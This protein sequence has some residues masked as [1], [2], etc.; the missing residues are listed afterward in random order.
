MSM[1]QQHAHC[2]LLSFYF[3][4]DEAGVIVQKAALSCRKHGDGEGFG[5]RHHP[6]CW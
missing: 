6:M 2:A 3:L 1:L 4:D 5:I